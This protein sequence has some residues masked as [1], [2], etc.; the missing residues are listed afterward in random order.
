MPSQALDQSQPLPEPSPALLHLVVLGGRAD[1]ANVELHDVRLVAAPSLEA[2]IPQLRRQWFGRRRGLHID[3]HVVIRHVDGCRIALRPGPPAGPDRLWLVNLGGYD[4]AKLAE[5]HQ[6]GVVVAPSAAAARSRALKR[7][8]L[9]AE[10]RHK[11]DL[12]AVDDCLAIGPLPLPE[13]PPLQVHL[14]PDPQGPDQP[15]PLRPD[16]FGY[17][18]I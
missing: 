17:R 13:G 2:A 7:W 5:L 9:R 8:L 10:Q 12:L 1:G 3:S 4:P 14:I 18:P 6:V 11:D 15:Q 16:W